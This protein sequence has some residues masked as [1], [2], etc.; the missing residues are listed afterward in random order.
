MFNVNKRNAYNE[1]DFDVTVK[2]YS[3][4]KKELKAF[5]PELRRAMDREIRSNLT[6]IATLAKG[7]VPA[8]VMRNWRKTDNPNAEW[9]PRIGFDQSEVKKGIAVRQGGKRARGNATQSAWRIVNRSGAGVIYELAGSKSDGSGFNGRQFVENIRNVG[10][11]KT[12]RLIWRAWD[13]SRGE[14]R[15]TDDIKTIVAKYEAILQQSL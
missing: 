15:I 7:Y 2:D 12:S 5:S 3:K 8:N 14:E 9:G 1:I 6:P 4:F 13:E 10:G 11:K